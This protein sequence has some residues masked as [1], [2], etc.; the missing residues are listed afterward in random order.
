[1]T[2]QKPLALSKAIEQVLAQVDGPIAVKEFIARVL[3]I[4]PSHA[5]KPQN[6]IRNHLRWDD[7]GRTLVFLD[8]QTILPLRIAVKGARFRIPITHQEA[9]R[10]LLLTEPAF[11][12]FLR[13][14]VKDV[15]L[16]DE[17]G[18][19]LSVRVVT[20]KQR[21]AGLLGP[22]S[23]DT[24]ALDLGDWFHANRIRRN[25]SILVTIE[26]WQAGRFRLEH[27]P[28]RSRRQ[29]EI[30]RKNQ[31]LADLLSAML[32]A[33]HDQ[34]L[35][36]HQAILTAYAR[37]ADAQGYPGDHW[38]DVLSHDRRMQWDGVIIHYGEFRSPFDRILLGEGGMS[39]P[40]KSCSRAQA[41]QVYRF[42]AAFKYRPEVW[43]RI[44]IQGEDTLVELDDVLRHAFHHDPMDHIGG[45]W[46]L[47]RRGTGQRF[48]EV[49]LG[50]INPLGEGDGADLH[51]A[52]LALKPSDQLKYV[53]DFGDWIEHLIT[54]EEIAEPQE[55]AK[56]PRIAGRNKPEYLDC[57]SC[58]AEGRK[59]IATWRCRECS[60]RQGREVLVCEDC[61]NAKHEDH[62]T[63][64]IVY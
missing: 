35:F 12:Y 33:A 2:A 38:V 28:A 4:R 40:E 21:I 44:E 34:R 48:R 50:A 57:Q 1:M 49:E 47:V 18:R 64:E 55:R 59:T 11:Q 23:Y 51:I 63:E 19:P 27:E 29:Q 7:W 31:E 17:G 5:R 20:I 24:Y 45:F 61:L 53:Y 41:R 39:Q 58:K 60:E 54:L 3:A 15:Q 56:Y 46:K 30:Q 36:A 26:D 22:C 8:Q 13:Q 42:R 52:A 43:R 25:D 32:E 37:L 9:E 6:P 10:G 14:G 62:Y 16:L